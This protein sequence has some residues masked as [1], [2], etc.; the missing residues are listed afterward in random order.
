MR[1][2]LD[3]YRILG[4]PIQASTEQ[5]QQAYR[6]RV[7]QLP[8]REY[9]ELTIEARRQLL[10]E[11]YG[12][13]SDP[14]QRSAYDANFFTKTYASDTPQ[15]TESP[16]AVTASVEP[17]AY[18][19]PP[20]IDITDEEFLGSLLILQELGEYELVLHL[21]RSY[22]SSSSTEIETGRFGEPKIARADMVLTVAL[23]CLELGREQWQ[24]RRYE[25][26][27]ETLDGGQELL[28]REGLFA[29]VR[30]EIQ[31]DLYKLRPYRIL[32]LLAL[33]LEET[34]ER[35]KGVLLLQEMLVER[36]G[37]DGAGNDQ[38]GL[39]KENFLR[40]IQQLR[41][42]LTSAEQQALFE[43]EA[44]RPS[45]VATYLAVY[46][47][48]AR[49][50]TQ[51]QP[52]LIQRAKVLLMRLGKRQDVYLEQ[53]ICAL[54]LGQTEEASR[55]MDLS[56]EYEA[57]AFIRENSQ[58]APDLLP[59]LCL[60]SERW[61]QE[62]V[63]PHFRDLLEQQVALKDYFAD[64]RVQTALETLPKDTEATNEWE[65]IATERISTPA[66]SPATTQAEREAISRLKTQMQRTQ[67]LIESRLST[68]TGSGS[69]TDLPSTSSTPLSGT[70]EA[71][72]SALLGKAGATMA[73]TPMTTAERLTNGSIGA[74]NQTE[75]YPGEGMP[76]AS[77]GTPIGESVTFD[78]GASLRQPTPSGGATTAALQHR[79]GG[80]STRRGR[81]GRDNRWLN[82][83]L[84]NLSRGWRNLVSP[85]GTGSKA[86]KQK[87]LILLLGGVLGIGVLL[88]VLIQAIGAINR[89]LQQARSPVKGE[90]LAISLDKSLTEPTAIARDPLTASGPI[91]EEVAQ[92]VI[93]T[94]LDRKKEAF[95]SDHEIERLA[96]ILVNPALSRWEA[97]ART[98]RRNNWHR[99]FEHTIENNSI[100]IPQGDENQAKVEAQVR[101]VAKHYRGE[102]LVRRESYDSNLRVRYDLV[103]QNGQWFIRDMTVLK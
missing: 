18:P 12:V 71:T 88:L 61:L 41:V 32:E 65:A 48:L 76:A 23:A 10:D 67:A 44:R 99:E 31:S 25:E 7:Q 82:Q 60:Y 84:E 63:F 92:Q 39:N 11:A 36:G 1:I 5:L 22:L 33:P 38:S 29:G 62:E 89:N 24:Q 26:A 28:L 72:L 21:G 14:E 3:Y 16:T 85:A 93:Q 102:R 50:F 58:G 80:A 2:P 20:S 54:L 17:T 15:R 68:Q 101:E 69:G 51:R 9:S 77:V 83:N 8:R 91:T 94:W 100:Q 27:A 70:A 90:Q 59:G 75:T 49:G 19:E 95:G 81:R 96:Q 43:E 57:L 78:Q 66:A 87:R 97:I 55:A 37:I 13:L 53:S 47:L 79:T 30:G 34:Q 86:A 103:R 42:Y 40:F 52:E 98:A 56:G 45:A 6:D 74:P 4:L 35:R 73:Q 46:A 64:D